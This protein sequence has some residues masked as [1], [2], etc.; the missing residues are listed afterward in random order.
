MKKLVI[1]VTPNTSK[2]LFDR[3]CRGFEEKLGKDFSFERADD[4]SV[5]G[6]FIADIDGDVYD[7]SIA[8]KL[9][10]MAKHIRL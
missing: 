6:G 5:I 9:K 2:E 1:T 4:P 10:E 7:A 3:I 8:T